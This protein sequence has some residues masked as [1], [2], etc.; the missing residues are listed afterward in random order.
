M[1]PQSVLS[2]VLSEEEKEATAKTVIADAGEGTVRY[3]LG[4]TYISSFVGLSHLCQDLCQS[5]GLHGVSLGFSGSKS[6]SMY[7]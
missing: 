1:L 4:R 7:V 2:A 3:L 6:M 5:I